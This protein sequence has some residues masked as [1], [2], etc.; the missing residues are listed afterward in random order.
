MESTLS[1]LKTAMPG[2]N[3]GGENPLPDIK[4][5][6]DIHSN[7]K[8]DASIPPEE[9]QYF[10][11]GR[12]SSIL[13]YRI[14]DQYDRNKQMQEYPCIVLENDF[15]YAT[16][17]PQF[18]GKLWTL[19]DKEHEKH[20][21]Q[22]NP[23]FQPCNLALRNAWI[24]GGI[25]WNIG[26]TGHTPYTLSPLHMTTLRMDDGTPVLRMYEWERIRQ[27]T[28]QIDAYLPKDSKF[29][30][31][32]VRLHNTRPEEVPIY[33]WSNTAVYETP[34]TRVLC[35][36]DYAFRFDYGRV[37]K[38][39]P[40]PMYEEIDTSYSARSPH[41]MDMFYDIPKQTRKWE[42]A[43]DGNGEGLVQTSTDL[44][45]GR[46]LF[47]WGNGT[48]GKRWQEFLASR[49][50][51]YAEIQAGLGNTQ[52]EH[53]PMPGNAVWE[54]VE[55]YGYIKASPQIVHSEDWKKA[56]SHVGEKLEE[57]LPRKVLEEE[58]KRLSAALDK[59]VQ[60]ISQG[61]GWGAL[62]LRRMGG[63]EVFG[64][65]A[66][67]FS[68]DALTQEQK[69]WQELLET[70]VFPTQPV[71][72]VPAA[73]LTQKEWISLLES[74]VQ[75][76][77]SDHWHGY[78]QLGIMYA[79]N[80]AHGKAKE[81]FETSFA[82]TENGWA[83]RNLAALAQMENRK[84]EAAKLLLE[85]A[86][87]LPVLA[88]AVECGSLLVQLGKNREMVQ[89]Y[90]GLPEA[91]KNSG[92][93]KS[94]RLQAAIHLDDFALAQSL[95]ASGLEVYDIREGEVLLSDLWIMLYR[96]IMQAEGA[97]GELSDKEVVTKYPIPQAY[98]FRMRIDSL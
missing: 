68:A 8:F 30:F 64:K 59:K 86:L 3:L 76:G 78:L 82:K 77:K 62:E 75:S 23:V 84:E 61:S 25:E 42:A 35:P 20:L 79:A 95:F 46:K 70:G 56:Y 39:V 24:S 45:Q 48:G 63:N 94:I 6:P 22:T 11:Y 74:S 10:N 32:R 87:L 17:Y 60:P 67:V 33:W 43:L 1:F 18:G 93:M 96:K 90:E 55:A 83:K 51:A 9:S 69:P 71:Q 91:V 54:W 98:D 29:L 57:V 28:Y 19:Y 53:L 12:V 13:P 49:G 66:I 5:M 72:E 41:A 31:V 47:V 73:Y 97:C 58:L 2:A 37:I 44:L 21:V 80:G 7:V 14:Q 27:V 81:C 26:M 92:R 65:E 16:F 85:A 52:M 89:F 88:I 36:A 4:N 15:I 40:V 34:D 38:K 50:E